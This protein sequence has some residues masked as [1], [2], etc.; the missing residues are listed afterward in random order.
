MHMSSR[1][2]RHSLLCRTRCIPSTSLQLHERACSL[3]HKRSK[4]SLKCSQP[5]LCR[6]SFVVC[7]IADVRVPKQREKVSQTKSNG[8]EFH[9]FVRVVDGS[10]TT[11]RE[12]KYVSGG[13]VLSRAAKAAGGP[14][15]RRA[16]ARLWPRGK[17]HLVIGVVGT[18]AVR[19]RSA[20]IFEIGS[21]GGNSPAACGCRAAQAWQPLHSCQS[22]F[23]RA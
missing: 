11:T 19:G 17:K 5:L 1:M 14:S 9:D 6:R 7:G 21:E 3:F 13:E 16:A 22:R 10:R 18:C 15:E 12:K 8:F 20:A 23:R 2:R 4:L